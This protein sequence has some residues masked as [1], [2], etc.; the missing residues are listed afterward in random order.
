MRYS[1]SIGFNFDDPRTSYNSFRNWVGSDSDFV[2][3][4]R[5]VILL[6][7]KLTDGNQPYFLLLP[8]ELR[9]DFRCYIIP[10]PPIGGICG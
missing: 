7:L 6:M 2:Y 8:P 1:D 5:R 3:P 9:I 4:E 10:V